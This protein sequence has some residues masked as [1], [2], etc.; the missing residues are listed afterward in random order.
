MAAA[1]TTDAVRQAVRA[2]LQKARVSQTKGPGKPVKKVARLAK[3]LEWLSR[4]PKPILERINSLELR[5]SY[6]DDHFGARYVHTSLLLDSTLV[7]WT[8]YAVFRTRYVSLD[9]LVCVCVCVYPLLT[10]CYTLDI[11]QERNFR[12]SRTTILPSI[13]ASTED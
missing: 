2:A 3:T 8:S 6:R 5:Y 11:L 4:E 12:E 7:R 9:V 1:Q 10:P 13:Y